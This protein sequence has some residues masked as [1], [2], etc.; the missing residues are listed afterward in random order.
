[1]VNYVHVIESEPNV[2]NPKSAKI[3][4]LDND[5]TKEP[6]VKNEQH[7]DQSKL[8]N[9]ERPTYELQNP[10]RCLS[11]KIEPIDIESCTTTAQS[12]P[13][14]FPEADSFTPEMLGGEVQQVNIMVSDKACSPNLYPNLGFKTSDEFIADLQRVKP[15]DSIQ[16]NKVD[17][18]LPTVPNESTC[19]QVNPVGFQHRGD[20][21]DVKTGLN[22]HQFMNRSEISETINFAKNGSPELPSIG[23]PELSTFNM[24]AGSPRNSVIVLNDQPMAYFHSGILFLY[25]DF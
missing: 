19:G 23:E 16:T 18:D 4:E 13:D 11:V 25:N 12:G 8:Y 3:F 7:L 9:L 6:C 10:E 21:G 20:Q 1:M 22:E 2:P 24:V 17:I 15:F 5:T 14:G